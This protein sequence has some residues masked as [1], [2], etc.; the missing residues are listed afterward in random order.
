LTRSVPI[1]AVRRSVIVE[2]G[3]ALAFEIFTRDIDTWW[4]KSHSMGGVPFKVSIIEPCVGGRWYAQREDGT[5]VTVAHVIAWEPGRRVVFRWEMAP[6]FKYDPGQASELE[7]RFVSLGPASTRV[8]LEHRDF[9]RLSSE[10]EAYRNQLDRG[11][12]IAL[13]RFAACA[14][15]SPPA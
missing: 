2:A 12:P 5:D 1:A 7:V 4:P 13:D 8:E 3:C 11:W 15:P 9:D 10:G 14:R 6:G